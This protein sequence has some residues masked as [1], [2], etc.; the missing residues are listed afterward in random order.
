MNFQ[1][2]QNIINIIIKNIIIDIQFLHSLK[3]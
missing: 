3:T 1:K 2:M